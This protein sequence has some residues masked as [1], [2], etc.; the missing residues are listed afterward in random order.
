MILNHSNDGKVLE[1][2]M[3]N[4]YGF[5]L[6]DR[7]YY[8]DD[9][10]NKILRFVGFATNDNDDIFVSFP[11]HFE[12]NELINETNIIFKLIMSHRQKKPELYIGEINEQKFKTNYPF[13]AFYAIYD[14]YLNY[15]LVIENEVH[16]KPN[17]T[18]KINWKHTLKNTNSYIIEEGLIFFPFYYEKKMWFADILAECMA[19]VINYTNSKFS[20][21]LNTE[22]V[23]L[24]IDYYYYFNFK[25]EIIQVLLEIRQKVYK[26]HLIFL[27]ENLLTFFKQL[28]IGGSYYIKHY[29]FSNIW[30]DMVNRYLELNYNDINEGII[31]FQKGINKFKFK[32]LELHPNLEKPY[33]FIKPDHLYIG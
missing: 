24:E 20:V 4:N 16:I 18:G 23:D 5:N 19:F 7:D 17:T 28:K 22:N 1:N 3:I 15:G 31:D 11:K 21:L 13:A 25:D 27:V 6:N 29:S 12:V 14:Y 26:D 32:S 9:F 30:E 33:Q 8:L 2:S 10:G